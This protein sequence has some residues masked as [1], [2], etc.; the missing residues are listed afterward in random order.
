MV[1]EMEIK[2]EQDQANQVEGRE[3]FDYTV[4]RK[5]KKATHSEANI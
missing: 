1:K 2:K 3:E 4:P 5:R